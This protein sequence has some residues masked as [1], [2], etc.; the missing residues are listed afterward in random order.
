[1]SQRQRIQEDRSKLGSVLKRTHAKS[2]TLDETAF[3][4]HSVCTLGR[5]AVSALPSEKA[6]RTSSA[7]GTTVLLD[8]TEVGFTGELL[9][10]SLVRE[11]FWGRAVRSAL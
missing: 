9:A 11:Q 5:E 1:M 2:C 3:A 7:T 10:Y 6:V 8:S 4:E